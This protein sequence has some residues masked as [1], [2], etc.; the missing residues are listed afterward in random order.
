M[1]RNYN[2]I[3]SCCRKRRV[4]IVVTPTPPPPPPPPPEIFDWYIS[5][6][7]SDTAPG[8]GTLAN[9]YLTLTKAISS[10]NAGQKIGCMSGIYRQWV[11]NIN[12]SVTI[13]NCTGASPFFYNSYAI[14]VWSKTLGKTNVYEAAC[15][16][17]VCTACFNGDTSLTSVASV[18]LCDA[19]T[20]SFYFDDAGNML[21]VNIGGG[22]P[23]TIEASPI[24]HN[25]GF[26]V[27]AANVVMDGIGFKNTTHYT[28][29]SAMV[30]GLILRNINIR[31][32]T[33]GGIYIDSAADNIVEYCDIRGT[34]ICIRSSHSTDTII[35]H[36]T[37]S[38]SDQ[39]GIYDDN[40]SRTLTE[41]NTVFNS[42]DGISL[43]GAVDHV[44][45][46]NVVYNCAHTCWLNLSGS[47]TIHHN[48]GYYINTVVGSRYIMVTE[49][50]ATTYLYNNVCANLL[51]HPTALN[52]FGLYVILGVCTQ[53]TKNNI[54]Y[55]CNAGAVEAAPGHTIDSDYNCFYGNNDDYGLTYPPGAHDILVDPQFVDG[56]NNNFDI[57]IGSPCINAG[58][59]VPGITD[60][61]L[62][63]A[64]DI[65][66]Y[67]KA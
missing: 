2:K 48:L 18:D 61:Y 37:L 56:M 50:G 60:G 51:N 66:R 38:S 58:V 9:P 67:E 53:V 47:A 27:S 8:D 16:Q 31:N 44:S 20:N 46:Y 30:S 26:T 17:P 24:T 19:A 21:Y 59:V 28:I 35:R 6:T 15:T 41:Y 43:S 49:N 1:P 14:T 23:T 45:R 3:G 34:P 52:R 57:L 7:G 36:N 63:T 65:G 54:F 10:A 25:I 29:Y 39:A 11:V 12:K 4:Q 13:K 22:A 55:R 64:P 33:F 32:Y 42:N 5:P 62:G 40:S